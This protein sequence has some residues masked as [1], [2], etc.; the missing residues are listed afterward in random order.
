MI[1]YYICPYSLAHRGQEIQEQVLEEMKQLCQVIQTN[2]QQ[3]DGAVTVTFGD[4]FEVYDT[5]I[6]KKFFL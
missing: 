6:K 1:S 5:Y 3:Q 4:L 2:G